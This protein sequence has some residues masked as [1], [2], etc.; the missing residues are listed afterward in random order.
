MVI[1]PQRRAVHLWNYGNHKISQRRV[2][3][4]I[5][6]PRST[7]RYQASIKN[8][9]KA[10]LNSMHE[11]VQTKPEPYYHK[12]TYIVLKLEGWKVILCTYT[13]IPKRI[14]QDSKSTMSIRI[15]I[16]SHKTIMLSINLNS[17]LTNYLLKVRLKSNVK[18]LQ[19][20]I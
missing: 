18:Y 19:S 15:S 5:N 4:V 17:P 20:N 10:L 9:E 11:L 2:Y 16:S 6:H 8:E 13:G 1:P 7:Q 3:K 12:I 14:E